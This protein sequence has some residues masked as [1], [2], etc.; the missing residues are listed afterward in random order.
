MS[1]KEAVQAFLADLR[2]RGYSPRT[3]AA[4]E[5]DLL[6]LAEYA[7]EMLESPIESIPIESVETALIRGWI[8]HCLGAGN[9]ARTTA[10]KL[11][12]CKSFF[13]FL[14]GEGAIQKNPISHIS[15]PKI[16]KKPPLSLSQEEIRQILTAPSPES[17]NYLRDRAILMLLYGSGLR[18]SELVGLKLENI[19]LDRQTLRVMGKGAKE[20]VLPL[21]DSSRHAI[22]AYLEAREKRFPKT[23]EPRA[24]AFI[25]ESGKP[26]SVRMIQY[27]VEKYGLKSGI[28][29]HVH[30]HLIRHSIATH[31]VEEGCSVEAV[32]QTLGHENL[33]TTS[34]YVKASS[35]FLKEEHKKF[36]PSDRL[37]ENT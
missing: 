33:A 10:R 19:L 15:L 35:K 22:I 29:V 25:K 3:V 31:L 1:I 28:P 18:V 20:R 37:V 26:L 32:R 2:R 8:D 30:P 27:L 34:I 23:I 4:Y 21:T 14:E 16:K 5:F 12:T 7:Q 17:P 11:A 36:N 6:K 24:P 13:K 9:T